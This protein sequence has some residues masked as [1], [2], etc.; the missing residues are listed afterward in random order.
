MVSPA[1]SIL[2][3]GGGPAQGSASADSAKAVTVQ[4]WRSYAYEVLAHLSQRNQITEEQASALRDVV[5]NSSPTDIIS[6]LLNEGVRGLHLSAALAHVLGWPEFDKATPIHQLGGEFLLGEDR[7]L[8]VLNPLDSRALGAIANQVRQAN[9]EGWGVVAQTYLQPDGDAPYASI[10]EPD[11][12]ESFINHLVYEAYMKGSSDIHLMPRQGRKIQIRMR[13]DGAL[14]LVKEIELSEYSDLAGILMTKCGLNAGEWL[15]PVD[16][17][18]DVFPNEHTRIPNRM[19]GILASVDGGKHPKFT[20]RLMASRHELSD[21]ST[22]GFSTEQS[23]PQMGQVT[24]ALRRPYGMVIVTGPTG[25]GKS[26]TLF[27]AIRWLQQRQPTDSYYTLEDPVETELPGV[28]Q[29][30]CYANEDHGPTFVTG[31]RNLLRQDPDTILLGEIRDQDTARLAVQ[32]AITGHRV[33]STLHANSANGAASRLRDIGVDPALMADALTLV[34]AQRI[35]PKLCPVCSVP[36][37]WGELLEQ[38][39]RHPLIASMAADVGERIEFA[40]SRYASLHHYPSRDATVRLA[41]SDGCDVCEGRGIKG[42]VLIA[43]VLPVS[44]SLKSLIAKPSTTESILTE[45]AHKEGFQPMWEHAF[46]AIRNGHLAFDIAER[47]LGPLPL[48]PTS[49][50]DG[51]LEFHP[52]SATIH[53]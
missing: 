50:A 14:R 23:N 7:I 44:P 47:A 10:A 3:F 22:L 15:K 6:R 33:F 45:E 39:K 51:S 12:A 17:R 18:F 4:N 24:E 20:I 11:K 19:A 49:P 41:K 13:L 26:T 35:I 21:L 53:P 46:Q 30:Q 52:S 31:L 28:T 8:Y 40:H 16:G 1:T 48:L 2:E 37:V 38:G 43:E 27:A 9:I 32:A 5:S 29:I 25:S 36:V 34:S 42:R